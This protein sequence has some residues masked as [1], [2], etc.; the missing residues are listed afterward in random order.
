MEFDNDENRKREL[1][2][3]YPVYSGVPG[4]RKKLHLGRYP[5]IPR[6]LYRASE[7]QKN[8]YTKSKLFVPE[9]RVSS[10]V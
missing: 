1:S 3:I 7:P 4:Y 6:V 2:R 10:W 9:N 8:P 5:G